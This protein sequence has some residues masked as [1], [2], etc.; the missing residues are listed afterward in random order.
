MGS[1]RTLSSIIGALGL[2]AIVSCTDARDIEKQ[3]MYR[4]IADVRVEKDIGVADMGILSL[5][6]MEVDMARCYD[7]IDGD[8]HVSIECGGDDCDDRNNMIYVGAREIC[9]EVDNDCDGMN[10]EEIGQQYFRDFDGDGEGSKDLRLAIETCTLP[11]EGYVRNRDDCDDGDSM[12]NTYAQELCDGVDN[13]C[14][15]QIDEGYR[16][17]LVEC[18]IGV[19]ACL[20]T[21]KMGCSDDGFS[22][23][24]DAVPEVGGDEICNNQDD[25][26]DG[27]T[28]EDY[29][30]LG[31]ACDVGIGSCMREGIY[32]CSN[33]GLEEICDGV[34]GDPVVELCD[35]ADN[36]CDGEI[37]EDYVLLGEL[38]E[39]GVGE[40]QREG[41]YV[42]D[43][44]GQGVAC[45]V[46][47]PQGV[48]ETCNGLD[49]DCDGGVD[50][51]YNVG[52]VCQAGV[53]ACVNE[54]RIVCEVN[55]GEAYCN[56]QIVEGELEQCDYIDNDCDNSIDE[57]FVDLGEACIVGEGICLREG[58]YVC[59]QSGLEAECSVEPGE[60]DVELCNELD[61]D[62]DGEVDEGN[63]CCL[64]PALY[65][66]FD[67]E[68]GLVANDSSGNDNHG[69]IVGARRVEGFEGR[70]LEFDGVNDFVEV[71]YD[72]SFDLGRESF[73][74]SFYFKTNTARKQVWF[75]QREE[76]VGIKYGSDGRQLNLDT[77]SVSSLQ[78]DVTPYIDNA[79]HLVEIE[80]DVE[81]LEARS[82]I[83]GQVMNQQDFIIDRNFT[84]QQPLYIGHKTTAPNFYQGSFDEVK[85]YKCIPPGVGEEE[86]QPT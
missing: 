70:A 18:E 38:C 80:V 69:R 50:E 7:D 75:K 19:G 47:V 37:D 20:S 31:E 25:D 58:I 65:L 59:S 11:P 84:P 14:D 35:G 34:A 68:E 85:I 29:I 64:D 10:D 51:G 8:G 53:G 32:V 66:N 76:L 71:A 27:E 81:Q 77:S 43:L 67:E 12:I 46:V 42:C 5:L 36:D 52:A 62:C 39:V 44:L 15:L 60:A 86:N 49:D 82:Y 83:D 2:A 16:R 3:D 72:E 23:E 22:V 24:C 61:D 73:Y 13:N 4:Q 45:D 54:G 26:C 28:D 6:D 57:D 63:A 9:D 40:C 78:F 21:G 48:E 79:W 30:L 1:R 55:L 74:I 33:N 17:L 41:E 56:A